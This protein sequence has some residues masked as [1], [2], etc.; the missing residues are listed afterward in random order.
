MNGL[1]LETRNWGEVKR[2]YWLDVYK[3]AEELLDNTINNSTK[4]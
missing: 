4:A 2:V 3:L 1:K